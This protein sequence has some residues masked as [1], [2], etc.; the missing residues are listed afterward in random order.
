MRRYRVLTW[1]VHGSYLYYLA[2]T[3]HEIW[4]PVRPGAGRGADG[5]P[6]RTPSYPWPDNVREVPA[7]RVRDL[8]FDLV[9]FQSRKNWL[10]DQWEILS[11]DQ[12]RLPKIYLEHDPPREHPTDTLHPVDD[13]GVLLVHVTPFNR[14]MWDARRTPTVVIEHGVTEPPAGLQWT[15]ELAKGVT[16]VNHLRR[17]GRRLGA[18]VFEQC[19]GAVPLDL[20]GMGW[21]E[22]DGL[23]EIPHAALPAFLARYR[24]FF[25]PIRYTSLGLSICEAM[26][27]G[28]PVVGLATTE[29]VTVIRD[30]ESGILSTRP[31][32]LVEGMRELI[33]DP[34]EA[35]RLG[36]A[37][38]RI[39]RERFGIARFARDWT[40]VFGRVCA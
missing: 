3:G 31:E 18:D 28:L 12:R 40:D 6:G 20:V 1:H 35:R 14:L 23:G 37:A 4:L 24:F 33:R 2:Q 36:E 8:E 11:V 30:G 16:V 32:R 7:D 38:R 39:A 15:G 13:P 5:Y 27:T 29:L 19:R 25:N 26:M 9:L 21:E 10:E 22:S 17:R 34:G